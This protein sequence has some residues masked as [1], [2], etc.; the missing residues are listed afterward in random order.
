MTKQQM[1]SQQ[2]GLLELELLLSPLLSKV[3]CA[4]VMSLANLARQAN[5]ENVPGQTS[6][7]GTVSIL[8]CL[9]AR[10]ARPRRRARL[11]L[12]ANQ[13]PAAIARA[14]DPRHR[15][16]EIDDWREPFGMAFTNREVA[17]IVA[18]ELNRR[19]RGLWFYKVERH[20]DHRRW[21]TVR[22][23]RQFDLPNAIAN[24]AK[25]GVPLACGKKLHHAS[26]PGAANASMPSRRLSTV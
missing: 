25:R 11:E 20:I 12:V 17:V 22:E 1:M 6:V 19:D 2:I 3:D 9:V 16:S 8:V 10:G 24:Y 15:K 13:N 7:A 21:I 26:L 23:D 4:R 14:L 5:G 18:N